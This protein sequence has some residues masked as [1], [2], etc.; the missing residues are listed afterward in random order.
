MED[1]LNKLT[2]YTF[3]L[4]DAVE[5][6]NESNERPKIIKH[7]AAVAEMYALLHMHQT[8]EAIGHIVK[9]ESRSHSLSHLS[10]KEGKNV[11]TKWVEFTNAAGSDE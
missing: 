2:R 10:G 9:K 1:I 5:R 7:L 11:A 4:K 8:V 6:T 3:A